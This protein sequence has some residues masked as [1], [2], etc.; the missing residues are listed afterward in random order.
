MKEG[1]NIFKKSLL[2]MIF[3]MLFLHMLQNEIDFIKLPPLQGYIDKPQK[4]DL[5]FD[6]WLSADYQIRQDVYKNTMF[7]FR[8]LYVRLDHQ[9]A[10]SFFD[11][12]KAIGVIKGKENYFYEVNSFH[13]FVTQIL[14]FQVHLRLKYAQK[15]ETCSQHIQAYH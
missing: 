3:L 6:D 5:N 12:I 8:S 13:Q 7:G 11:K 10:F 4:P 9:I 15:D 1:S 14:R 2:G